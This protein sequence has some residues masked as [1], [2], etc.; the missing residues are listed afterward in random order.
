MIA[1]GMVGPDNTLWAVVVIQC[2]NVLKGVKINRIVLM[3]QFLKLAIVIYL[4]IVIKRTRVP[5][6]YGLKRWVNIVDIYFDI[7][8]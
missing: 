5:A 2:R 1:N 6:G 4:I 7:Y 8:R 3:Q